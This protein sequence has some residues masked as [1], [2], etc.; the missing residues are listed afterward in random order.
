MDLDKAFDHISQGV[1]VARFGIM[2]QALKPFG[3]F[4]NHSESLVHITSDIS[5]LLGWV[6]DSARAATDSFCVFITLSAFCT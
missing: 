1:C 5:D 4:Y 3:P 2:F 6:L